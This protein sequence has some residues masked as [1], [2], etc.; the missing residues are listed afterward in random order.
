M[1]N[2]IAQFFNLGAGIV[3]LPLILNRLS[4]DEVGMN[5]LMLTIASLVSLS[6]FGFNSQF[7][8]NISY[9]LSGAQRLKKDGLEDI[10]V[11]PLINYH[12]LGVVIETARF[13]YKRISLFVLIS[14]ISFGT[15]YIYHATNGFS[16]VSSSLLIWLVFS[17]A[18][19]FEMY[20]KYLNSLLV[21][22][23]KIMEQNKAIILNKIGYL[24][25]SISL[26]LFGFGLFSVVIAQFISPFIGRY[27][28]Y[29]SFFTCD[30]RS[31]LKGIV[32]SKEEIIDTYH[33]LWYNAKKMGLVLLGAYCIV[34]S[35][36]FTLGIFLPL[37]EIASYGL[38]C[39]LFQVVSN[40][41]NGYFVSY[42]PTIY[43]NR[44]EKNKDAII[45]TFSIS[46][47]VSIV[48]CVAG[49]FFVIFIAPYLIVYIKSSSELPSILVMII[50]WVNLLMEN[51]HSN[52]STM[53]VSNNEVPFVKASLISGA[54]MIVGYLGVLSFTSSGLLGI[55]IV[56]IIVQSLYNHWKWPAWI[57]N[58]LD[59][60]LWQL[61]K[62]GCFE[63][64][65]KLQRLITKQ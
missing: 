33:I 30:I 31:N 32:I 40:L 43:K 26:L 10:E 50:Y 54:I 13:I 57:L 4:A 55:V 34:H 28:A 52:C 49:G 64:T 27:Y 25:I 2:Y 38:M 35:G 18:T 17:F 62:I 14:M 8:R 23:A 20:F 61:I 15:L 11:L 44:V 7:G 58:D 47:F 63:T 5:Y 9:V 65:S 48:L 29:R 16:T 37:S 39:Q 41:S 24:V 1:W 42:L 12:L 6:D 22:A 53:I 46:N 60:S 19:F 36:T 21:G 56:Q 51:F 45:K 59:I 3:I